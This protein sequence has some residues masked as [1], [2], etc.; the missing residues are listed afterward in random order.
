MDEGIDTG[1]VLSRKFLPIQP[2]DTIFRLYE[3]LFVLSFV[4]IEESLEKVRNN[5]HLTSSI[6]PNE[7]LKQS[8]YSFQKDEDWEQFKENGGKFI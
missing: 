8:Y 6:K 4:A 1:E 7:N 5:L 2:K 3:M